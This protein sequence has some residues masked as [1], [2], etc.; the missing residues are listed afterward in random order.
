MNIAP[1]RQSLCEQGSRSIVGL[2]GIRD[3]GLFAGPR[4]TH[5]HGAACYAPDGRLAWY[6]ELER[7]TGVKHDNKLEDH[8]QETPL[9]DLENSDDYIVGSVTSFAGCSFVGRNGR[10]RVDCG[11]FPELL[12]TSVIPARGSGSADPLR[13]F[14]AWGI[15][16][17]L[18][19]PFAGVAFTGV[20][21]LPVLLV[22]ADGGAS[23]S[24][25]S[26]FIWTEN[27]I[28]CI[29]ADWNSVDEAMNFGFNELYHEM[30]GQNDNERLAT[31]GRLM[32]LAA[33]ATA[34]DPGMSEWLE[35]NAWFRN[36]W[37]DKANFHKRALRQYGWRGD[38]ADLRDPF[39]QRLAGCAQH[40]L[41]ECILSRLRSLVERTG[42]TTLYAGGGVFL[43]I[44]LNA[45]IEAAGLFD[46]VVIPPNASDCGLG[47]GAACLL[48]WLRHGSI[49]QVTPF[50]QY[51]GEVAR[52]ASVESSAIREAVDR[53]LRGQALAIV[54][55]AAEAG[56]RALGHRSIVCLPTIDGAV[57][58]SNK[59]KQ[60]E[61]YR[62]VAP[63]GLETHLRASFSGDLTSPLLR[64]MLTARKPAA[65]DPKWSGAIHVDGTARLQVIERRDP[66][67]ELL[68][69]VLDRVWEQAHVPCL[70]NT[71]LNEPGRPIPNTHAEAIRVAHLLGL[72]GAL[73]DGSPI[74]WSPS[75][76]RYAE[77]L[78]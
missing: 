78:R 68:A 44:H 60:R 77:G 70:I 14:P 63:V 1:L 37:S 9:A 45:A 58:V 55:G 62:P 22:H 43:N 4:W 49:T 33:F 41:Q 7:I 11:P 27:S 8:W 29:E 76:M 50:I 65:L 32:G 67:Q 16:Q 54:S 69:A 64:W 38:L 57:R 26:A 5:D 18:A 28:T 3:H 48:E 12:T 53:L 47:L 72:D 51:R 35:N 6:F 71:S 24:C 46:T 66:E 40:R 42:I 73:V 61:W 36:H 52:T 21:E 23:I 30:L 19:H 13:T 75:S 39:V 15:A 56:P 17:E 2:Y 34:A 25:F 59:V 20:P 74:W 31:A 10:L